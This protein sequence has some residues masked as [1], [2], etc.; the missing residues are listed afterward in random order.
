MKGFKRCKNGH[1]HKENEVCPYCPKGNNN[2][3]TKNTEDKTQILSTESPS[4][5]VQNNEDKTVILSTNPS[6]IKDTAPKPVKPKPS[7]QEDLNRTFIKSDDKEISEVR[8]TRK[9]MGW[10]VS[11]DIDPMGKD[12][13]IFEGR[14]FVGSSSKCDIAIIGDQSV[15]STQS[16]ILCKK[17]KFWLRDEMSSNGTFHNDEELEPN[18][19]PEL[20]DGDVI[21]IGN[22]SFK[23]KT[24][25]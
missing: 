15:S 3:E 9:L 1:I 22:C 8:A 13:K 2:I 18:Q 14:N 12:Y 5:S 4:S 21:K 19:S 17:N 16:L 25:F 11:F 6:A 23:F 10:I 20:S 24:A 7:S